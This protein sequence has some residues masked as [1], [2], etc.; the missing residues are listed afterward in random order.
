MLGSARIAERN[1]GSEIDIDAPH[2]HM[3]EKR[4]EEQ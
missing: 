4:V 1:Q 2:G 3:T